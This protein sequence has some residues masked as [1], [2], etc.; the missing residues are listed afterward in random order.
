MTILPI[1]CILMRLPDGDGQS[2]A[3][4]C[5]WVYTH[6]IKIGEKFKYFLK[7]TAQRTVHLI[8]SLYLLFGNNLQLSLVTDNDHQLWINIV[9]AA[10][11]AAASHSK[12]VN[13]A[14]SISSTLKNK[15]E[16]HAN[17]SWGVMILIG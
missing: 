5:N 1:L 6:Q 13:L 15:G 14:A 12:N 4:E 8:I 3:L 11:A 17:F 7:T 16:K 10:S 2:T 9:G